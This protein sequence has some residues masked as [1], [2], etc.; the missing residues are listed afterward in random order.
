MKNTIPS[1]FSEP[2]NHLHSWLQ[3]RRCCYWSQ[4][5]YNQ[6]LYALI[7][8]QCPQWTFGEKRVNCIGIKLANLRARNS[9]K[10]PRWGFWKA[11][12]KS[13]HPPASQLSP[14]NSSSIPG[15]LSKV[16][17]LAEILKK[18]YI[19]IT[20]AAL[21]REARLG[22]CVLASH[23]R[24]P[25]CPSERDPY[26]TDHCENPHKSRGE[27]YFITWVLADQFLLSTFARNHFTPLEKKKSFIVDEWI[28]L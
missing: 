1:I 27:R 21:R 25:L 26:H 9:T 13:R 24:W 3:Q 15:P 8:H 6:N 2:T 19:I 12:V 11:V 18:N 4:I 7:R 28:W 17:R 20:P 14:P 23:N 10:I 16:R 5:D 22:S